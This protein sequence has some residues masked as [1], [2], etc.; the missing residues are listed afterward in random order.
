MII[1]RYCTNND[2]RQLGWFRAGLT[3]TWMHG[4]GPEYQKRNQKGD[5]RSDDISGVGKLG[6]M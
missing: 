3:R 2:G 1:K 5:I 4:V 6:P